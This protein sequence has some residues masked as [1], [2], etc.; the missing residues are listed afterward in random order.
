MTELMILGLFFRKRQFRPQYEIIR[1]DQ[2]DMYTY[3]QYFTALHI[4]L[5]VILL[6]YLDLISNL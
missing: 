3:V 2:I 6:F 5:F 4:C 1:L